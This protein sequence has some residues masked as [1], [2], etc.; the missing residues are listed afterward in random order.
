MFPRK[1]LTTRDQFEKLVDIGV[2]DGFEPATPFISKSTKIVTLGSCFAENVAENLSATGYDVFPMTVLDRIFTPYA[3]KLFAEGMLRDGRIEDAVSQNLR[4]KQAHADEMR[5]V[6]KD[7]A[8]IILTFGFSMDWVDK[9]T[10]ETILDP[11]EKHGQAVMLPDHDRF[12]M[13]QMP[14]ADIIDA[15]FATVNA[16]R[17][18]NNNNKIVITLSPI[19][20]VYSS[21]DYPVVVADCI[22]KSNL[23]VAIDEILRARIKDV[24]YFP[25]FEIMRWAAPIVDLIWFEDDLQS[26]IRRDWISYAIWKFRQNFCVE[27]GTPQIAPFKNPTA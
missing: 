22:S 12:E 23:R 10:G 19:P 4:V 25:S 24:F 13:R 14:V 16:L 15:I 5:R 20:M 17:T 11:A 26:H 18:L 7:G 1:Q 9:V 3:F 21:C 2:L 8:V 27:P 6:I